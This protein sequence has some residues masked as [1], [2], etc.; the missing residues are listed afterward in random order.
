MTAFTES[1][2]PARRNWSETR[3]TRLLPLRSHASLVMI[4]A[5]SRRAILFFEWLFSYVT[6]SKCARACRPAV[7]LTVTLWTKC[8]KLLRTLRR[9]RMPSTTA[10]FIQPL[11]LRGGRGGGGGV[12]SG[13]VVA[14]IIGGGGV[15][16][17][18]CGT[19]SSI[20]A[21]N[22]LR[23]PLRASRSRHF[24]SRLIAKERPTVFAP[25][26]EMACRAWI[27]ACC[28]L[29]LKRITG[30]WASAIPHLW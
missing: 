28:W 17:C 30:G 2:S 23:E 4:P 5:M 3:S 15:W 8:P 27:E 16:R 11:P 7:A 21:E 20:L 14:G 10:T 1:S 9:S 12:I 13:G 26:Q 25:L 22:Y 24:A 18:T 19:S 29:L 6:S